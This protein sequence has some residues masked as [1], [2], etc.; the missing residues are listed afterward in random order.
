M[1][2]RVDIL[3]A[4]FEKSS[5]RLKMESQDRKQGRI[6]GGGDLSQQHPLA[7]NQSSYFFCESSN[8]FY[9]FLFCKK[10]KSYHQVHQENLEN[11]SIEEVLKEGRNSKDLMYPLQLYFLEFAGRLART[12]VYICQ[13]LDHF[14]VIMLL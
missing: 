7:L 10:V 13:K 1:T 12:L 9:I 4:F 14:L 2:G 6:Q 3:C 5:K 11:I 8:I